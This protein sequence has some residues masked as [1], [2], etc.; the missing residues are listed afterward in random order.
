MMWYMTIF[1]FVFMLIYMYL[2]S[3]IFEIFVFYCYALI[4]FLVVGGLLLLVSIVSTLS[5][6]KIFLTYISVF[7]LIYIFLFVLEYK[8]ISMSLVLNYLNIYI[9]CLILLF[10]SLLIICNINIKYLTDLYKLVN[11]SFLSILFLLIF[12]FLSGLPPF[13]GF[14]A[15]LVVI[16]YLLNINEFILVIIVSCISFI[17]LYFYIQNY[18]FLTSFK[19]N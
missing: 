14:W 2:I 7:H 17:L 10:Y 11:Y 4:Y 18:R 19:F 9:V 8:F 6:F 5:E 1:T 16:L 12:I 15:K 13:I 3:F